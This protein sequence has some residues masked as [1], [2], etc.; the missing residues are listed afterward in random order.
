MDAAPEES[1]DENI[2][3]APAIR[4]KGKVLKGVAEGSATRKIN[5][6]R[7]QNFYFILCRPVSWLEIPYLASRF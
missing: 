7:G 6:D 2:R 3:C 5:A 1:E 4:H